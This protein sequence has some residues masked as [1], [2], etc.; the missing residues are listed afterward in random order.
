MGKDVYKLAFTLPSLQAGGMERVMAELANYYSSTEKIEVH[1]ILFGKSPKIFYSLNNNIVIHLITGTFQDLFRPFEIIRR[2]KFIR[3]KISEI[4]PDAVLS[5]GTQ[6]NNFVLYAL[7]NT[8]YPVFVSD[9][10]SP[11]RRYKYTTEY[12]RGTLYKYSAGIIAQTNKANEILRVRFPGKSIIAIGN[13]IKINRGIKAI[14]KENI[15]LS[16]GRLIKTKHHDRL[17]NIFSGLIAPDWKLI[18]VGGDAL[19]E[20]NKEKL[21]KL[22]RDLKLDG[23]V[24]L[25]GEQ[26]DVGHYYLK[27]KI[28]AFT[29]SVEGFPNVIGEALSAGLPVV[30]YDC[31]AGP[32][33]MIVDGENGFLVPV[34]DDDLFQKRLQQLIDDEELRQKMS[35][36][37]PSSVEKFSIEKIGRQYLDFILS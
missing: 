18:I 11:I 12:L 20:K 7:H 10:G 1:L 15:I 9:R 5:F 21:Q 37:A 33:E 36:K 3:G 13:P 31:V 26:K 23:R 34:F 24:I 29:S 27:G 28:F 14:D 22:I 4:Q 2:I 8:H 35:A 30:S 25:T 6:W 19:K 16:V 17:I 32:S